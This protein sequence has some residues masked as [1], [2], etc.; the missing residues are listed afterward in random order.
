MIINGVRAPRRSK[1]MGSAEKQPWKEKGHSSTGTGIK[2]E[3]MG[4][5]LFCAPWPRKPVLSTHLR[6]REVGCSHTRGSW[7]PTWKWAVSSDSLIAL[8]AASRGVYIL[9]LLCSLWSRRQVYLVTLKKEEVGLRL[10]KV[11]QVWNPTGVGGMIKKQ[12]TGGLSV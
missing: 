1:E 8:V 7:K 3:R 5:V 6:V 9:F 12:R 4:V 11:G 10:R 2:E